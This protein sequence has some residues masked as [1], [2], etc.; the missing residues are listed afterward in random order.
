MGVNRDEARFK[1]YLGML[2]AKWGRRYADITAQAKTA[3]SQADDAINRTDYAAAREFALAGLVVDAGNPLLLNRLAACDRTKGD[4]A[5]MVRALRRACDSDPESFRMHLEL[6]AI[7]DRLGYT[8]RAR[9]LAAR[10]A[11]MAQND[12]EKDRVKG[13]DEY[14]ARPRPAGQ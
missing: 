6:A 7:E 8:D 11:V 4:L 1:P 12:D 10:L 13:L 2:T 5:G 14:L 3:L 9:I